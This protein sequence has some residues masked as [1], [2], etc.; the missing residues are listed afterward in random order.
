MDEDAIADFLE[1]ERLPS[2][3]RAALEAVCRPV[4]DLALAA[5]ARVGGTAILGLCGAQGSGKTTIA[6]AVVALSAARGLSAAAISLDDFYLS[7]AARRRL[8]TEV[9]PLFATRGPPGTHDVDLACA[10]LDALRD[11]GPVALPSFDKAADDPRPRT[12]W[13]RVE[14]PLDIVVLEGWCVGARPQPT[15][16]LAA[17]ANALEAEE[18]PAGVWRGYANAALAGTYQQLWGRLDAL[19]FLQAPS[20]DVVAGWR[21][22]QEAKLRARTGRGMSDAEIARFVAHYERLTRWLLADMPAHADLTIA[23]GRDRASLNTRN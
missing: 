13:P 9:H 22:E 16:A 2:S 6:G 12:E 3:S 14:A 8:A 1:A 10:T 17:P 15:Q 11:T 20:F 5:R 7:H 19:A 23:L 18:D 4:F 21:A